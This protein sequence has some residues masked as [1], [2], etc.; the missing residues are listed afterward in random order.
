MASTN[1]FLQYMLAAATAVYYDKGL[2]DSTKVLEESYDF[3][4]I[5]GGV[6]GSIV[7]GKLAENNSNVSNR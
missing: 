6:A 4:I 1:L 5:G 2:E 7:A 3:V